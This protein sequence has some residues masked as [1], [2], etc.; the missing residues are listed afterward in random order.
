M[1]FSDTYIF[2]RMMHRAALSDDDVTGFG[3]LTAED[4]HAEALTVRITPVP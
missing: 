1:V 2:A 3:M 4:L